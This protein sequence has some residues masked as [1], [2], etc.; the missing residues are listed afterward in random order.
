MVKYK[1][2]LLC[3][4]QEALRPLHHVLCDLDGMGSQRT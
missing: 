4:F 2:N 3:I 1:G